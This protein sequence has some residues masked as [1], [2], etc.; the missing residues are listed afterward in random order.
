M[1]AK[2]MP[3]GPRGRLAKYR[4]SRFWRIRLDE[5]PDEFDDSFLDLGGNQEEASARIAGVVPT[6]V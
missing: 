1:R 2:K 5:K 4:Q 6:P 3:T